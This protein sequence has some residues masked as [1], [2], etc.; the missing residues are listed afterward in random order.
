[1]GLFS[2]FDAGFD[3]AEV[4]ATVSR[5][6]DTG[7]TRSAKLT[8]GVPTGMT[9]EEFAE[10]ARMGL[11]RSIKGKDRGVTLAKSAPELTGDRAYRAILSMADPVPVKADPIPEKVKSRGRSVVPSENSTAGHN[12]TAHA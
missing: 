8:G 5:K 1:M 10:A 11:K 4:S 12:G 7:K 9:V 6:D 3:G 2:D